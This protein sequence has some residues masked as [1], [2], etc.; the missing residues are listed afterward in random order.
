MCYI[1]LIVK[2]AILQTSTTAN[3]K[4]GTSPVPFII[5]VKLQFV[6]MRENYFTFITKPARNLEGYENT[7]KEKKNCILGRFTY[8]SYRFY[9]TAR[10][11]AHFQAYTRRRALKATSKT[12]LPE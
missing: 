6:G 12:M 10:I 8:I 7:Q 5:S 3:L 9:K 1:I 4:R 11:C 2:S